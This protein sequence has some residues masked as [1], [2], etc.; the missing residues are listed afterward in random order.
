MRILMLNNEYPPLGGGQANAN[1]C[2]LEA[3]QTLK[4][5]ICVDVITSSTDK[6]KIEEILL[7]KIFYLNIGKKNKNHHYQNIKD[8]LMYSAKS[9]FFAKKRIKK[10]AYDIIIAW[11][12]VPSGFIA[13]LLHKLFRTPYI[14][15]LRGPDVPF[16]EAKWRILDKLVFQYLSPL[17]WRNACQVIANSFELK[18][19]AQKSAKDQHILVI[20]NGVDFNF[21]KNDSKKA[22]YEFKKIIILSVGRIS[23]IKGFDL[24]IAAIA[25]VKDIE[26]EYW[27]VGDGP[28]ID[29]LRELSEKLNCQGKTKFLGIKNKLELLQIYHASTIFC[30]PSYN[31]G[32]S[33]ALLEAMA[34]GLPVIVTDVG[35][36]KELID[37]NGTVVEKGDSLAISEALK[38][39]IDDDQAYKQ[40]SGRSTEIASKK[41]WEAKTNE[42]ISLIMNN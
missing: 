37:G 18:E 17:I 39:M 31:E 20:E 12:G 6:Y 32:M 23:K 5:P 19:L 7:G 21:W 27:I 41:S 2:M 28:E 13:Y 25:M 29:N 9:F 16:H 14:V 36:T 26:L 33:N 3:M 10:E 40:M 38:I 1:Q 8:L 42:L 15:L 11:A 34:A 4:L 35:G 30:L 22:L 24:V